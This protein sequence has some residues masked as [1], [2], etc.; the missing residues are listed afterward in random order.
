MVRKGKER[1]GRCYLCKLDAESNFHLGVDCPFTKSVWLDIEDKLNFRNLW[2]GES[3]TDC[4]KN[5][6][7]N[8][9][10]KHI[11]SLPI[12]VLWFLWK[13]RY[14]SCFEDQSL[15]PS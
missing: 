7:L 3:V 1:P 6:C 4:L 11:R 15:R 14:Q 13:A 2:Y 5:R 8:M 10:G 12:M 9:Q